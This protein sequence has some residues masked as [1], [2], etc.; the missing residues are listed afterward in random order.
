M[1][2][3]GLALNREQFTFTVE[4]TGT[5][6]RVVSFNGNESLS[7]VYGYTVKVAVDEHGLVAEDL[8]GKPC[9]LTLY[10]NDGE[11]ARYVHGIVNSVALD[12]FKGKNSLW[13]VEVVPS[14]S[15]LGYGANSRIFQN[16]TT[17]EIIE[18]VLKTSGVAADKFRV[19]LQGKYQP[20][21]Y[22]VQY[23]E[24]DWAFIE[25]LMADEGIYYFFE[26]SDK[27]HTLV[28]VDHLSAHEEL[29][30]SP[31]IDYHETST[32]VADSAYIFDFDRRVSIVAGKVS[33]NDYNFKKP[34]LSLLQSKEG[35]VDTDLEVYE[36]PASHQT[37]EEGTARA[38]TRLAALT[39]ARTRIK[40]AA[41]SRVLQAG[42]R[43]TLNGHALEKYNDEYVLLQ[44]VMSGEQPGVLAEQAGTAESQFSCTFECLPAEI[45]FRSAPLANP[46]LIHG[47][48]TAI[49]VG[50][51]GEEIYTDEHGRVKVQ[52]HWDR[53]G[54]TDENS[55]CWVRVS[56]LWAGAGWG[57]MFVPRIGQEVI[58]D[59]IEGNP[60]RPIITGRVYHGT[61]KPPYKLPQD[62]TK[63]VIRSETSKGGGS[64]NELLMED[65]KDKTQVMLSNAYGHKLLQDEE[66]QS[67]SLETRDKHIV[68]L[69]DKEKK[70]SI[71]T[72]N[73]HSVV[74]FDTE[75]QGEGT[76]TV[77]TTNAHKMV[78]DDK[79]K[80]ITLQ[81]TDGH[82]MHMD[83]Q[84]KKIEVVTTGGH[85]LV[86]DDDKKAIGITSTKGHYLTI[87]DN[88]DNITLE[89]G[90]G[91]HRIKIDI[92][93]G[94]I[95][96]STDAGSINLE[97]PSGDISMKAVN[98]EL[99]AQMDLKLKS[100]MN[101][102]SEA[103]VNHTTKGTMVTAEAGAV[104]T[105]KGSIVKIN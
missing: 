53:L 27:S 23:R 79:E 41:T 47:V 10:A 52:F 56:Q 54:K 97:A 67:F 48:Q 85:S 90:G 82:V 13:F 98:I 69:D 49:V 91:K 18:E 62:K 77:Q 1:A 31:T 33:L 104:H 46:P 72:T 101:T 5:E 81:T 92:G 36:Y 44:V 63:S 96:I 6:M 42:Y 51:S 58:V 99:D 25:R 94:T 8:L 20:R 86:M 3:T 59:F 64:N 75:T 57:A 17:P 76:I 19:S 22:C 11:L 83:D 9:L 55:S 80:L 28:L 89:D 65:L 87:D 50:P 84:N 15:L 103:G 40:G 14:V 105:V 16:K 2:K 43:F 37:P 95:L 32:L 12:G 4:Q 78:M 71:T 35:E 39:A 88:G 26:H 21:E 24:S 74:L 29:T 70:F 66:S 93:G 100:G 68:K 102:T 60:D 45:Q 61:N 34:A 38:T 7:R 73:G 30:G